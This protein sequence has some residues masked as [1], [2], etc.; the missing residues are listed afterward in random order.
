MSVK[1]VIN[2]KNRRANTGYGNCTVDLAFI[3]G[4]IWAPDNYKIPTTTVAAAITKIQT[5]II[6]DVF[7]LR[8]FPVPGIVAP[9]DNTETLPVVT[10]ADGSKAVPRDVFFDWTFQNGGGRFCLNYRL[11]ALLNYQNKSFFFFDKNGVL[12]GTDTGDGMITAI[13]PNLTWANVPKLNTGAAPTEY[14]FNVNYDATLLADY[15]AFIDFSKN[16]GYA[17]LKSLSGLQDVDI[18]KV[19][20]AANVLTV[21]A[22]TNCGSSN[23]AELYPT[24]LAAANQWNAFADLNGA[25]GNALTITSVTYNAN[26]KSFVITIDTSDPDYVAGAPIWVS[27]A[28][29][30]ETYPVLLTGY[31]SAPVSIVV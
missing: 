18:A 19:T 16:G 22:F 1:N 28:G 30:T 21:S 6:N 24:Q 27:L 5:D 3:A 15:P 12:W 20:R 8:L 31:E 4:F 23:L 7:E 29:P 14:L 10:Y 9:T 2:C 13:K 11:R 25:P 26:S 17:F